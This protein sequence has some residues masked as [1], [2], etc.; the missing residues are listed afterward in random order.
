VMRSKSAYAPTEFLYT[1]EDGT[2]YSYGYPIQST[3]Q[4]EL[5][6]KSITNRFGEWMEF[7]SVATNESFNGRQIRVL[8]Q[9][10]NSNGKSLVLEHAAGGFKNLYDSISLLTNFANAT[11]VVKYKYSSS[12]NLL[13][14]VHTLKVRTNQA[15]AAYNVT[16]FDYNSSNQ[17]IRV[18]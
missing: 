9:V 13:V 5:Y 4:T 11:P 15:N 1:S 14:E 17:L 2:V 3:N 7:K 18:I 12:T 10:T 16:T 8:T 6:L